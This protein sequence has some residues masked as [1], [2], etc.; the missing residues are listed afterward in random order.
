V[1]QNTYSLLNSPWYIHDAS[2][3]ALLP[4]L[5]SMAKSRPLPIAKE[6]DVISV[7]YEADDEGDYN[8]VQD[9]RSDARYIPVLSIKNAIFKYDQQC[10]PRGTQ[11]MM[12]MMEEWKGNDSIM[13]VVLDIDS[14]GG[15]GAGTPEFAEY[16]HN[17]PKPV[18]VY[19]NGLI[20][21][22]AFWIAAGAKAGI[23]INKHADFVGSLGAMGKYV[24]MDGV[25]RKEGAEIRD[26]YSTRSP[27]KNEESRAMAKGD[28]SLYLA[29]ILD[30]G[31]DSIIADC[32]KY[33]PQLQDEVFEGAIY[34]P[35][36]ALELGLVD[37]IGTINDVFDDIVRLSK[38]QSSNNQ[39]SNT[40]SKP[41]ANVQA[42]LGLTAPLAS[43]ENGSYLN[44]V[45]LDTIEA[46]LTT[47][48]SEKERL[49]GELNTA[50]AA[51]QKAEGD[52]TIAQKAHADATT[53]LDTKVDSLVAAAG[54]TAEGTTTEKLNALEA[55]Y[56]T[57]N[58]ADGAKHTNPKTDGKASQS[59][60]FVDA[61]A[62][63]NKIADELFNQ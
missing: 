30:P 27:R 38:E 58:K 45:Q 34:P 52:L 6:P 46:S 1:N 23:T 50:T 12:A 5:L 47:A 25:L 24:N 53:A 62:S 31:A 10:G 57:I 42:V 37:R 13:G 15:Q 44:E 33:R 36:K 14:G 55:H 60:S 16:I 49:Q 7:F 26:I 56:A 18:G 41:R 22:A 43:T 3:S 28:D 48:N 11:T 2:V 4:F 20:C 17:Y 40:M 63:H 32:K 54:I 8:I 29:N 9:V 19:S 39:N 21:S 61:N 51:Q 59:A 35:E